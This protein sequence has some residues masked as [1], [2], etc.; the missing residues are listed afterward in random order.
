MTVAPGRR[1]PFAPVSTRERRP[2]APTE[3]E[4]VERLR[5][6]ATLVV[7]GRAHDCT[8]ELTLRFEPARVH[9]LASR[10]GMRLRVAGSSALDDAALPGIAALRP[11]SELRILDRGVLERARHDPACASLEEAGVRHAATLLAAPVRGELVVLEREPS[12]RARRTVRAAWAWAVNRGLRDVVLSLSDGSTGPWRR[13]IAAARREV[14]GRGPRAVASRAARVVPALARELGHGLRA[15]HAYAVDL[16][17][18]ASRAGEARLFRY[19]LR[20]G[21]PTIAVAG[22]REALAASAPDGEAVL[23]LH[24]RLAYV[25]RGNPLRQL[26]EATLD[27]FPLTVADALPPVLALDAAW[28]A[29]MR[30]PLLRIVRMASLPDAYADLGALGAMLARMTVGVHLWTFRKPEPPLARSPRRLP[31]PL[32]VRTSD[33]AVRTVEPEVVSVAVD[34]GLRRPDESPAGGGPPLRVALRLSRYRLSSR[35]VGRPIVALHGYSASGTTF[36]HPAVEPSLAAFFAARGRDVWVADLRTSCG[37]PETACRPWRFEDVAWNDVPAIVEHVRRETGHD[38]VDVVAHCMGAVMFA[39]AVLR[40][41]SHRGPWREALDALPDRIGRAVL[42]QGG[43]VLTFSPANR[44]RALVTARVRAVF[45]AGTWSMRASV[46]P[47]ATDDLVDRLL[48]AM[49][50]RDERDFREENPLLASAAATAFVRTRH[51]LDLLFGETFPMAPIERPVRDAIDD[52]FGEI[53][54]ETIAQTIRFAVAHRAASADGTADPGGEFRTDP[55]WLAERWRF[56][57][58]HFVGA[59]NGVLDPATVQR[60]NA[61]FAGMPWFRA[62][63]VDGYG[64]QDMLI[65]RDAGRFLASRVAPFLDPDG[66]THGT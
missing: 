21:A 33:G 51:R 54:L 39:M 59:D 18:L 47:S 63:V 43:P 13:A 26:S 17:R 38:R 29:R 46:P 3:V 23:E 9:A 42:T 27:A 57:T 36:A 52:F 20:L 19:R 37:L 48:V 61:A 44:L 65:G 55:A 32:P 16:G 5:G 24:K 50:Y 41:P 58:R 22:W 6:D 25:P 53:N 40:P 12:T 7:D 1:P 8:I 49:P 31:G 4:I 15:A 62:E 30:I 45:G 28:L 14:G 2:R 11:A 60:A 35:T 56:E 10:H 64:H 34:A 66:E